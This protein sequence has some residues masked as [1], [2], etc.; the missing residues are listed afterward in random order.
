M[1]PVLAQVGVK[2]VNG[3]CFHTFSPLYTQLL[4]PNVPSFPHPTSYSPGPLLSRLSQGSPSLRRLMMPAGVDL[5]PDQALSLF[6]LYQHLAP[7]GALECLQNQWVCAC[8]QEIPIVQ[9]FQGKARPPMPQPIS[10]SPP[11]PCLIL[12]VG[13]RP[14]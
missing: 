2:A 4:P 6:S 10:I 14:C 3:R 11:L 7:G 13:S 9:G 1:T 12:M 8:A 5:T